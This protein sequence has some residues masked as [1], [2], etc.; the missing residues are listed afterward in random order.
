MQFSFLFIFTY[1]PCMSSEVG[2]IVSKG[3]IDYATKYKEFWDR[4]ENVRTYFLHLAAKY[5]V[6]SLDSWYDSLSQKV[7]SLRYT[8]LI[9]QLVVY[10]GGRQL[11]KKYKS[12]IYALMDAHPG[13]SSRT[14][15]FIFQEHKWKIW[16][17]TRVP[18]SL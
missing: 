18:H 8:C 16:K 3:V 5:R 17:F 1:V 10:N 14:M 12:P 7:F 2:R 4:K 9:A 11:L 15:I 6:A 13:K